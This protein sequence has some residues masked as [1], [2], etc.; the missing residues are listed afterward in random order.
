MLIY[1]IFQ[2]FEVESR[3][4]DPQPQIVENY[5][6]LLNLRPNN[7]DVYTV[8]LFPTIVIKSANKTE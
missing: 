4:R 7:L 1:L 3:Y 8:I 6:Y 2:P 5:S